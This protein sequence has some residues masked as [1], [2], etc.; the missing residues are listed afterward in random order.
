MR[1]V[2][3]R[4]AALAALVVGTSCAHQM[5]KNASQG[6]L[7]GVAEQKEASPDNQVARVASERAMLGAFDAMNDPQQQEVLRAIVAS[8]ATQA[9]TS[10]VAAMN[11]PK[12][13]AQM[14][15][16]VSSIVDETVS[17]AFESS[18][19]AAGGAN[20]PAARLAGEVARAA[21]RDAMAEVSA[22]VSANLAELFP[23][24]KGNDVAAC[25]RQHL[26]ALTHE[27]G[28]GFMS[29]ALES[30]R[31]LGLLFAGLLGLLIGMFVHWLWTQRPHHPAGPLV[32]ING[33]R[34]G[35]REAH[36]R[37]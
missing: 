33:G 19:A 32:S 10:T 24:C 4:L 11:D 1:K 16:L 35:L 12:Q 22:G 31:W 6:F 37:H 7:E 2:G 20:G 15:A 5:G 21:T 27:A 36:G 25:R 9:A 17:T 13:R 14:A 29:G 23:G 8:V 26:R 18:L 30:I 3:V 34:G 28:A